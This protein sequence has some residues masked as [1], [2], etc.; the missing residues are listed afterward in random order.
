MKYIKN[1]SKQIIYLEGFGAIEVS[2]DHD[3]VW[4]IDFFPRGYENNEAMLK[5]ETCLKGFGD[6]YIQSIKSVR[7]QLISN[8]NK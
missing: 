1:L 5:M 2:E 3:G 7:K 8:L 6:K 4:V